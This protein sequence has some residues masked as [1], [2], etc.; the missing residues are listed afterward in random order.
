MNSPRKFQY[1]FK[2]YCNIHGNDNVI[3]S[4][5][6]Y[7][8]LKAMNSFASF[9]VLFLILVEAAMPTASSTVPTLGNLLPISAF[10]PHFKSLS[11]FTISYF[12]QFLSGQL[13][14]DWTLTFIFRALLLLQFSAYCGRHYS[15]ISCCKHLEGKK[16]TKGSKMAILCKYQICMVIQLHTG[17]DFINWMD[18]LHQRLCWSKTKLTISWLPWVLYI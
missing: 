4:C 14:T 3:K 13:E 16:R 10:M 17:P 8:I 5:F 11:N 18:N 15:F 9:M 12:F 1:L 6:E 7:F 2:S